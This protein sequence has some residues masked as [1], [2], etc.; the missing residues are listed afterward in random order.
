[1]VQII[2]LLE[3]L[4][5]I[6]SMDSVDASEIEAILHTQLRALFKNLLSQAVNAGV[7]EPSKRCFPTKNEGKTSF[8]VS[9]TG[10]G[11]L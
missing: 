8:C 7:S 2:G 10:S 6:S 4:S 1:M 9:L 5:I 11:S 3:G